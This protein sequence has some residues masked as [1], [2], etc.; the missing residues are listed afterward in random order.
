MNHRRPLPVSVRGGEALEQ[1][2]TRVEVDCR[3][4]AG[5]TWIQGHA[6]EDRFSRKATASPAAVQCDG[7]LMLLACMNASATCSVVN[8]ARQFSP[9]PLIGTVTVDSGV[10]SRH[11]HASTRVAS[12]HCS[13]HDEHQEFRVCLSAHFKPRGDVRDTS[14]HAPAA[15]AVFTPNSLNRASQATIACNSI[16][17]QVADHLTILVVDRC[18][19]DGRSETVPHT[20]EAFRSPRG[21]WLSR[22]RARPA[23]ALPVLISSQPRCDAGV[24]VPS[25]RRVAVLVVVRQV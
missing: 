22:L 5:A 18:R 4:I 13:G 24:A 23:A 25:V 20:P 6:E 16:S 7:A 12:V 10:F 14:D 21:R 11:R 2:K 8:H 19:D 9:R 3:Q 1:R 15:T 17:L